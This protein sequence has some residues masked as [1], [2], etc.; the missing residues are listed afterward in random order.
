MFRAVPSHLPWHQTQA[1]RKAQCWL[2]GWNDLYPAIQSKDGK[3]DNTREKRERPLRQ[4][5]TPSR[6]VL[7]SCVVLLDIWKAFPCRS[8]KHLGVLHNRSPATHPVSQIDGRHCCCMIYSSIQQT[9]ICSGW[10]GTA[11]AWRPH[12]KEQIRGQTRP[13][14]WERAMLWQWET[15]QGRVCEDDLL[16]TCVM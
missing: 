8:A 6:H 15:D 3:S 1:K 10:Y 16:K 13:V 2:L 9:D 5:I 14:G 7:T 4:S 11:T 12:S